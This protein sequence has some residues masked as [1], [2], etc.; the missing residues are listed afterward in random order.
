MRT[1]VGMLVCYLLLAAAAAAA[2]GAPAAGGSGVVDEPRMYALDST[3]GMS[4]RC[5]LL[6]LLRLI[7]LCWVGRDGPPPPTH[8]QLPTSTAGKVRGSQMFNIYDA[9]SSIQGY[10]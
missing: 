6:L 10:S 1:Q 3:Q 9:L 2:P 7:L 8:T 4:M 5:L